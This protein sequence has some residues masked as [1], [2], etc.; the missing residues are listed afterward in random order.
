MGDNFLMF[1]PKKGMLLRVQVNPKPAT[2]VTIVVL[3]LLTPIQ[4]LALVR[5]VIIR[6]GGSN[7]KPP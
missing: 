3:S 4:R 7:Q 6:L 2:I 5:M 1:V